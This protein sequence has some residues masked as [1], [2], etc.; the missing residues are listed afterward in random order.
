MKVIPGPNIHLEPLPGAWSV[1]VLVLGPIVGRRGVGLTPCWTQVPKWRGS[2]SAF[3]T[4]GPGNPS[5]PLA[6]TISV[7]LMGGDCFQEEC[8]RTL[9]K[10]TATC[11]TNHHVQGKHFHFK[12]AACFQQDIYKMIFLQQDD[13]LLIAQDEQSTSGMEGVGSQINV[14]LGCVLFISCKD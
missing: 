14:W 6:A 8:L 7:C 11:V 3:L 4:R 1:C 9:H 12:N 2:C 5:P 13:N 10:L